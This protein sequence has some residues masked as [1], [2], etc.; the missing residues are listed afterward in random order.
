MN[1][2]VIDGSPRVG[3]NTDRLCDAFM[4]GAAAA[5]HTAAKFR[6]AGKKI[7][8]CIHCMQCYKNTPC[9][10]KDDMLPLYD[11]IEAAD[12]IVVA[13]PIYFWDIT[14]Q[15]KAVIDRMFA[16]YVAGRFTPKKTAAIFVSGG[17]DMS[18]MVEAVNFYNNVIIDKLHWNDCG[19]LTVT[20]TT[21]ED[22]DVE[23]EG[24][25]Q[26]AYDMGAAL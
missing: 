7:N 2:L 24:Y 4:A 11:Q 13:S 19:L 20:G 16:L 23:A 12:M 1:I 14:A 15:T 18:N 6:V 3:K 21:P 8:G 25:L 22:F 17:K 26:K 5:G 10:Q 9:S